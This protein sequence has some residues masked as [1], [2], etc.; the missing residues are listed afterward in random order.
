MN[1]IVA[2]ENSVKAFTKKKRDTKRRKK[3]T[4]VDG[5]VIKTRS[6]S[7]KHGKKAKEGARL[8]SEAT[9][10]T[11]NLLESECRT[12]RGV[13]EQ[14]HRLTAVEHQAWQWKNA[15]MLRRHPEHEFAIEWVL[16][17]KGDNINPPVF[18]ITK[19]QKA[20][21]KRTTTRT[22]IKKSTTSA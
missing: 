7:R 3:E 13:E 9:R 8:A 18:E 5:V 2:F 1:K 15:S 20:T 21:V 11:R 16:M 19:P 12:R 17:Q 22:W 6:G 4:E 14:N 10:E